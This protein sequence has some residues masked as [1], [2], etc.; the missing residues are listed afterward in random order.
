MMEEQE[1]YCAVQQAY[2]KLKWDICVQNIYLKVVV[3][4]ACFEGF[5]LSTMFFFHNKLM[6][7][8]ETTQDQE[9]T[10]KTTQDQETTQK[11]PQVNMTNTTI[12][13]SQVTDVHWQNNFSCHTIKLLGVSY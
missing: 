9:T 6:I 13:A 7:T 10:Q 8:Q 1:I 5:K 11:T 3:F 12:V 2:Q 4:F